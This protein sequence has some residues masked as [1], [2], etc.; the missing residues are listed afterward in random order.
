MTSIPYPWRGIYRILAVRDKRAAPQT[1]Q[2]QK[3]GTNNKSPRNYSIHA[4]GT[5][6]RR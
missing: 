5:H 1:T 2:K 3:D 4:T 6:T